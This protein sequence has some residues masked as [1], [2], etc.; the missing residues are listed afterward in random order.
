MPLLFQEICLN[1]KESVYEL[2]INFSFTRVSLTFHLPFI[3]SLPPTFCF[4]DLIAKVKSKNST[5]QPQ[6]QIMHKQ[7][8]AQSFV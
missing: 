5:W 6:L 4:H 7:K 2:L 8:K 1:L 3:C